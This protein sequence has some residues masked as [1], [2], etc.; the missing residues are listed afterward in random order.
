M[1]Q[2]VTGL[3]WDLLMIGKYKEYEKPLNEKT[4]R[5]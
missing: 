1:F 5:H 2:E 4:P 3:S